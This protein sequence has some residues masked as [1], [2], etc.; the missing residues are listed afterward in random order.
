MGT[1]ER[2]EDQ[3]R[4]AAKETKENQAPQDQPV[5]R[6]RW[7]SQEFLVWM[8]SQVPGASRECTGPRETRVSGVSRAPKDP[9][10]YRGCL[11]YQ[12]RRARADTS[13]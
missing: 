7:G 8:G 9:S 6:G 1:R 5:A 3:G 11:V 10:D 12:G 13:A 4:R 2:L